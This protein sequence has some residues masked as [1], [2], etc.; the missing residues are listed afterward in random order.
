[1][2]W[3]KMQYPHGFFFHS[4]RKPAA[5]ATAQATA[6]TVSNP[7]SIQ[8]RA[9]AASPRTRMELLGICAMRITA[10]RMASGAR[11]QT[12]PSRRMAKPNAARNGFQSKVMSF[13]WRKQAF[14]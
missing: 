9:S 5:N 11:A 14:L 10:R 2:L 6:A 13:T 3:G 4:G 1:M 8:P 7:F 12:R